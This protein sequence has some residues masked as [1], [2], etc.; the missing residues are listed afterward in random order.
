MI[1]IMRCRFVTSLRIVRCTSMGY[2][3]QQMNGYVRIIVR[4]ITA[5]LN[6][7]EKTTVAYL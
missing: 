1:V 6:G 3:N 7:K 2:E 5:K 4:F